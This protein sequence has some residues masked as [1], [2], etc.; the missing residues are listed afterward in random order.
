M[1]NLQAVMHISSSAVCTVIG[2]FENTQEGARPKIIAV[3]LTHTD[4]FMQGQIVNRE[5]L[6]SAVHKSLQ[7][8][9]DMAGV[10]I[11]NPLISFS[12]PLM[13]SDNDMRTVDVMHESGLIEA[14]DV[15]L[16]QQLIEDDLA[17]QDRTLLQCCQQMVM[18]DTDEQVQDAIGLRSKQIHVYNHV[19]SL[20]ASTHQQILDL[21]QDDEITDRTTVFDG[22]AGAHYALTNNEKQ[23]GVCYIDIGLS[24]T[25][26]CVYHEGVL[27]YSD[28]IAVGGR[29]VDLDIAKE[30]G[31]A[32]D[33]TESFKRQEGTL[34]AERYS[35]GSHVIYKK[36][37]KH[38]KTMLRREL[39]QV[40]EARYYGIFSEVFDRLTKANLFHALDAGVVLAGGACQMDGLTGFIRTNFGIP[41]RRIAKPTNIHFDPKHLSDD[42]IK[43]LKKHLEDNTLHSAIGL[44]LFSGS[45]Q[46][47][48]D[49]QIAHIAEEYS[50]P[51]ADIWTKFMQKWQIVIALFKKVA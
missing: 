48:R 30:C 25:K 49:Q 43:S 40:I 6:L 11:Y 15:H 28:C 7:E 36:G 29:T 20:P 17:R 2:Q 47:A 41:V 26:I 3:G 46:F 19:M 5:H 51:L 34:N 24:M 35:L 12:T 10:R 31:I 13:T 42:T 4:A 8:A 50:N 37:T 18:L 44:F 38:E 39:N 23:Q 32:L 16:A 27:I 45:E 14:Q 33:D 9:T 22:V 1:A 21:I